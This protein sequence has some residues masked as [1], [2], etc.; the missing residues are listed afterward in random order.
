M[1]SDRAE[2]TPTVLDAELGVCAL[3]SLSPD[4]CSCLT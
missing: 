1:L 2:A 4:A 3:E